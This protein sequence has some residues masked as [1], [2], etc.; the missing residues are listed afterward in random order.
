MK[1]YDFDEK[2]FDYVRTW[3]AMNPGLKESEIEQRY[4]E[5]MKSWLNA[6]AQWL[7]GVKPGEYFNRY[8]DPKD[9]MKLLE[10]YLKRDIGLPEPLFSRIVELGEACAPALVKLAGDADKSEALRANA[11]ALL[12]EIDTDA[13]KALYI[14]L[15]CG[16]EEQN[17]LSDMAADVLS[18]GGAAIVEPLLAR[19]D[20][21]TEYGQMLIL[22]ICANYPGDE[23][24][25]QNILQKLRNRPE[26][27]AFY[28]ALMGKLGDARA[29]E[30]LKELSQLTEL[31]Y[32][33]YIELRSAIEALGGDAGEERVFN[34]DPDYEA[35]RSI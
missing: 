25:Y 32:L 6:P 31:G 4:N 33:D 15:V 22:D 21:A 14:D 19:Y 23:R 10:E 28:A 9:L 26:Q 20:D 11:M 2:F 8:S 30:P 17:E 29:I 24:I 35:L 7:G 34:G 5:M 18:E 16:C 3:M 13:P 1:L 27:R 12:R